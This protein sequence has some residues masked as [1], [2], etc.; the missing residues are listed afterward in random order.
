MTSFGAAKLMLTHFEDYLRGVFHP[1]PEER[2]VAGLLQSFSEWL[3]TFLR[4][5]SLCGLLWYLADQSESLLLPIL[6][7]SAYVVLLVYCLSYINWYV[8]TPFH[9]VKHKRLGLFLDGVAT[10][11][12]IILLG[13]AIWGGTHLAIS[14]F[15]KGHTASHTSTPGDASSRALIYSPSKTLEGLQA[16]PLGR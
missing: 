7:I 2:I 10:V 5:A 13:S 16:A 9:F 4:N 8:L 15:S 12:V 3:F 14:A 6:A 1:I 11:G